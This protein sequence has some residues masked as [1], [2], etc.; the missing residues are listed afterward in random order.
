ME[1]RYKAWHTSVYLDKTT[2][3]PTEEQTQIL[4]L[5]HHRCKYEYL[6]EQNLALTTDLVGMS[7]APLYRLIHELPGAGKSQVL[8]WIRFQKS[9][10]YIS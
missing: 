6:V 8:L 1:E 3:T 5:I 9:K 2:K 4:T 10:G 7:Q